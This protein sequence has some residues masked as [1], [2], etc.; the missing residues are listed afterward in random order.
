MHGIPTTQKDLIPVARDQA[1]FEAEEEETVFT[2]DELRR[3]QQLAGEVLWLSQRTRPDIAYTASLISSLCA[4]APRRAAVIARKCIGYLQRTIDYSLRVFTKEKEIVAWTDASFA[5]EG[6]R[7]HTG[8]I[9]QLGETPI[10]WRSSRQTCVTLST[11]ESEMYAS[12]EGALALVSIEALLREL[13]IGSW[14]SILRTDSTSSESI[15]RGSGSWR[16]RH[17]RIKS[18]WVG[19][20]LE[21]GDLKLE[22]C[23]GDVQ[24]ADALTK[25][26]SS[27]RLKDLCRLIGLMPVTEFGASAS[28]TSSSNN[29]AAAPSAQG[30]KVL[31]ALLVLSQSVRPCDAMG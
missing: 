26:L 6:A 29:E 27:I 3:A 20:R 5:P 16:T 17:L 28:I 12:V 14:S 4:R 19:E 8:W 31:I 23:P 18:N 7:A 11:A 22:H 9:I 30:F 2:T 15:Q 1:R 24:R 25:A 13:E 10:S 21:K